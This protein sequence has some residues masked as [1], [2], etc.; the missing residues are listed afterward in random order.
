MRKKR[1]RY[2]GLAFL[3]VGSLL[4]AALLRTKVNPL[5]EELAKATVSDLASNII[6][7]A[8]NLQITEGDIQ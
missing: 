4:L 3:L 5:T 6:N 1:R 8:V 2:R 7:E